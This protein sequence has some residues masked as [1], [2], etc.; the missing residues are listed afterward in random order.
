MTIFQMNCYDHAGWLQST[1]NMEVNILH[2]FAF[3]HAKYSV[4]EINV[5]L[6]FSNVLVSLK[7]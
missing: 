2:A 5:I 4:L 6:T 7:F 1:V 3:I